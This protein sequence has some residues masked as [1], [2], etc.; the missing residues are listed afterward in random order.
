MYL[1]HLLYLGTLNKIKNRE[2]SN[3]LLSKVIHNLHVTFH[4]SKNS[5]IIFTS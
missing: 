1:L 3:F 2:H 4:L 5:E